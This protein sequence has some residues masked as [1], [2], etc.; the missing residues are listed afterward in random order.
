[1]NKYHIEI[2]ALQ[3]TRWKEEG[4]GALK[5]V[6]VTIP[7]A[8][9]IMDTVTLQCKYDLEGEP[10]YTVKWYKG[11]KE[12]FRYIP[13]EHPN[14][15]VFLLPGMD[16]DLSKS[17]ENEVV[18]R[19]VQPEMSGRYKCEVSTD[20]PN[21]YTQIV[22]GYMYVIDVPQEDPTMIIEKDPL[23]IG[24]TIKGN[25]TSPPSYPRV[26][27]TWFLNGKKVQ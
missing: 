2:L 5:D 6:A 18:L 25:C 13:K 27:I 11:T 8:A 10:L 9:K 21:F 24:Y 15:Q 12:F 7:Q 14:T 17:T 1:M 19:N 23:E 26:N 22:T 3:E 20:S 4:V 16:V